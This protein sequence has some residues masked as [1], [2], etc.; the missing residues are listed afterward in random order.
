[1]PLS[2][3]G[4]GRAVTL[5]APCASALRISLSGG[6]ASN[7][8]LSGPPAGE[9]ARGRPT[10]TPTP[11]RWRCALWNQQLAG[12]LQASES[13]SLSRGRWAEVLQAA[14]GDNDRRPGGLRRVPGTRSQKLATSVGL[15]DCGNENQKKL[16][17]CAV[18]PQRHP[19][20]PAVLSACS[21]WVVPVNF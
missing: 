7:L 4:G 20:P 3:S 11:T 2:A 5:S 16:F 18:G 15:L 13:R 8:R 1:L 19:N 10:V 9:L 21:G 17:R 12:G 14:S 6:L